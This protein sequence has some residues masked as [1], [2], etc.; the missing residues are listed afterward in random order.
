VKYSPKEMH[1]FYL[2]IKYFILEIIVF[3]YPS[4]NNCVFVLISIWLCVCTLYNVHS[5]LY[6]NTTSETFL[7]GNFMFL[8]LLAV[9][10]PFEC[11]YL[12]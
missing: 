3:L 11:W 1:N 5:I 12:G 4:E 9:Y 6:T 10:H 7:I 8:D 2:K